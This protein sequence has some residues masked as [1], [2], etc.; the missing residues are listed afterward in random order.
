MTANASSPTFLS[1]QLTTDSLKPKYVSKHQKNDKL[2]ISRLA[3]KQYNQVEKHV[4]D[5]TWITEAWTQKPHTGRM[6]LDW[7]NIF[8]GEQLTALGQVEN[9]TKCSIT[10]IF[11]ALPFCKKLF[12]QFLFT[13]WKKLS[14]FLLTKIEWYFF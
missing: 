8:H 14:V 1:S 7:F 11:P 5:Q 9:W 4:F 13:D 6:L 2:G 12:S 3:I 10:N